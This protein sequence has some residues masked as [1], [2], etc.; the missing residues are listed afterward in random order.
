[1]FALGCILYEV[2]TGQRLFSDDWAIRDYALKGE[3]I[4]PSLWPKCN[5]ATRFYSSGQLA[6]S[7]LD[8]DP[9][10]RPRAVETERRLEIIR[11]GHV[12]VIQNFDADISLPRPSSSQ[13]RIVTVAQVHYRPQALRTSPY[14][15][16]SG[17][18]HPGAK[19]SSSMTKA[20]PLNA[21]NV[22]KVLIT[23]TI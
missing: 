2:T 1:M 20:D 11:S 12:P 4:F 17:V 22:L 8:V 14:A 15:R 3:P 21:T 16:P 5:S 23:I 13:Q 6:Q 9:F 18:A 7:L 10:R 19:A